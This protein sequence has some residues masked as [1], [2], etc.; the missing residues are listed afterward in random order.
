[1]LDGP[2]ATEA[3]TLIA[4]AR[5]LLDELV[6]EGV[7]RYDR[8]DPAAVAAPPPAPA[9]DAPPEGA[10]ARAKTAE[11]L[12]L[13]AAAAP[14]E[15]AWGDPP[16][17]EEVRRVLGDCTRCGLAAGRQKIV[18]GDGNPRADLMFVGEGPGKD[19][20]RR[21]LPFV[22]RAGEL[23]TQ[24]IENGLGIPRSEVY[25]CNIV[26]CRPPNNRT[27]LDGE[28]AAC[29]PFLDGQIAAVR[30]KV[31]V[32]LGKPAASLLLGRDVAITR[33][34]GTWHTYHGIPLMPTLHPAYILRQYTP[35][36]RRHVWEDLKAALEKSR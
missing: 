1:M 6:E 36:N 32:A 19:E 11:A 16:E 10:A 12:P 21:G 34:R 20:D 3:R 18:F 8:P 33:I 24:M 30:P 7:D 26:K 22:G 31:I 4:A 23:L 5:T 28:V 29:R 2:L 35:E 9:R 15:A 13:L 27:P 17:L 25:I 14:A